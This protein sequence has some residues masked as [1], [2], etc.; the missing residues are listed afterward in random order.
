MTR[1]EEGG[2]R[3]GLVKCQPY[4]HL[5]DLH[6]VWALQRKTS[7]EEWREAISMYSIKVS[8]CLAHVTRIHV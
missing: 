6:T 2:Q 8:L 1:K 7:S 5:S 3:F 4:T